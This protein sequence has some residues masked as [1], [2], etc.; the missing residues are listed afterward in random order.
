MAISQKQKKEKVKKLREVFDVVYY[1]A[2]C[3]L[4]HESPLELLI[5]TQL[6]AQCTDARVNIVAKDLYKRYTN[7]YDFAST[8]QEELESYIRP[9]GFYHN[10]AKNIIACC[11]KLISDFHAKQS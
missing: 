1:D 11:Q 3:S 6:A 2:I 5:S 9:T 10:K 7:V 8:N 4:E